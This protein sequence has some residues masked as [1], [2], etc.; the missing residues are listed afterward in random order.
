MTANSDRQ[1]AIRA[2][3]L[4]KSYTTGGERTVVLSGVDFEAMAGEMTMVIGP[5]GSGKSTLLA[6]VSG[7]LRPDSGE[8]NA[9]GEDLWRMPPSRIDAFRLRHCGFVFQGFNL[10]P[11]L[12]AVEQVA[13]VVRYLGFSRTEAR[14]RARAALD[15]VGLSGKLALRPAEMSGGEKQRVAIARAL[16][17]E[18]SLVFAD[19]PSSA[20]DSENAARIIELLRVASRNRNAAVI[21]VTHDTKLQQSAD[22]I[23]EMADGRVVQTK[24]FPA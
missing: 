4:Q 14:E 6:A 23:V 13:L 11:A 21:V 19:E 20:L 9:L 15:E 5:S 17:K 1:P 22:R 12:N 3:G 10:F 2:T 18:P 24:R 7:L 16:V 8:V